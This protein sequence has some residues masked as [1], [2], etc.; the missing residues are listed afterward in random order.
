MFQDP[1]S[2]P[3]STATGSNATPPPAPSAS[4][5]TTPDDRAT[6]F[7][8]VEGGAT[9]QHSG[10]T[11]MVEAYSVLWVILMGWIVLVWR[12][13]SGLNTRLD[14]LERAIDAKAASA[15]PAGAKAVPAKE[16][17]S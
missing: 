17:K 8:A 14:E 9:E 10:T 6:T 3:S 13:Q 5:N 16:G 2:R 1:R 12:K 15:A 11:L 4:T 7:Q